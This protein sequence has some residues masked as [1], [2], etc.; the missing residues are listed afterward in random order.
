MSNTSAIAPAAPPH[1][2]A[3]RRVELLAPAKDEAI[4]Q[5]AIL[6]GADAVYVGGEVPQGC[7]Q[8]QHKADRPWPQHVAGQFTVRNIP[9]L[10]YGE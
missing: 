2:A 6:C 7:V 4:A 8:Q 3:K 10:G 1:D 9:S 5:A